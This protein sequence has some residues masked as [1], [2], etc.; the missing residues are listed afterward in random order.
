VHK[1]EEHR[2]RCTAMAGEKKGLCK[3]IGGGAELVHCGLELDLI[4]VRSYDLTSLTQG[5]VTQL[6]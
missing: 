3:V 5:K 2:C 1:I 4:S 6:D